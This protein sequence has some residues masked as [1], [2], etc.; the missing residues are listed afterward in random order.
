MRHLK[1]IF[2]LI[3]VFLFVHPYKKGYEFDKIKQE[4]KKNK[5]K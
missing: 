3:A 4:Y 5:R 2:N 1:F